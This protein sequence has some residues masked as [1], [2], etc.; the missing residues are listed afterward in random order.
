M[1]ADMESNKKK[2]QTSTYIFVDLEDGSAY[3]RRTKSVLIS[4]YV[5]HFIL[6]GRTDPRLEDVFLSFGHLGVNI[7]ELEDYLKHV[8][9]LPFARDVVSFPAGKPN[10][11]QIP[12]PESTEVQNREEHI[13][14]HLPL[15]YPSQEGRSDRKRDNMR[16]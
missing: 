9:P 8:D 3:R 12:H 6:V 4:C 13:P 7:S 1:A 5:L 11:L 15:M 14:D 16:I 10:N 2:N